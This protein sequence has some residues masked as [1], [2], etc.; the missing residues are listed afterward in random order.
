MGVKTKDIILIGGGAASLATANALLHRGIKNFIIVE[1]NPQL[2][3][4]ILATGNGRCNLSHDKIHSTDYMGSLDP[5]HILEEFGSAIDF[6][7]SLGLHC[8]IDEQGRIYPYCMTASSVRDVLVRAIP[9]ENVITNCTIKEIKKVGKYWY[10]YS[11]SHSFCTEYLVIGVGGFA[12]PQHG[13]D[14]SAWDLCVKLEVPFV[15][16]RPVLCPVLSDKRRLYSLHGIRWKANVSLLHKDTVIAEEY[17]EIQFTKHTLSGIAIFNLSTRLTDTRY[18]NYAIV[19][20][21]MPE[22]SR[23]ETL[24][25]LYLLQANCIGTTENLLSGIF[26]IPLARD[27]LRQSTI[28]GSQSAQLLSFKEMTTIADTMRSLSFRINGLGNWEQ[29][30]A[31][32][33]GIS[34]VALDCNLQLKLYPN[35]YVVGELVDIHS[36]CGGYHLHWCWASGYCVA[37]RIAER[38]SQ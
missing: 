27:I 38:M 6:F 4:K 7:Q 2:G 5:N 3:K 13:T 23:E 29:A 33:G 1:K 9:D 10:L 20:N 16:P 24:N 22:T 37:Q 15:Q 32:G 8:R 14:G 28:D 17:G 34:S 36:I 25:L 35:C 31:T 12:S 11:E 18:Q 21:C 26:P 30:Q 19:V